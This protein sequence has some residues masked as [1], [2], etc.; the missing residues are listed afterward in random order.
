MGLAIFMGFLAD[1]I[2]TELWSEFGQL[3]EHK[4]FGAWTLRVG[5]E[6]PL[7]L[8]ALTILG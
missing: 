5:Q 7:D 2:L 1:D 4:F 3:G 6:P 8:F